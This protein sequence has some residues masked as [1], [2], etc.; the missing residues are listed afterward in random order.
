[1]PPAV[2]LGRSGAWQV[3]SGEWHTSHRSHMSHTSHLLLPRASLL[4]PLRALHCYY[5]LRRLIAAP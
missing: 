5:G 2:F 1:M 3:A 4:L